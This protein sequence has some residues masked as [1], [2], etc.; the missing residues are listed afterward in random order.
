MYCFK[1]SGENIGVSNFNPG[2]INSYNSFYAYLK[3]NGLASSSTS[4]KV[5]FNAFYS[6]F[7]IKFF[8]SDSFINYLCFKGVSEFVFNSSSD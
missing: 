2:F 4:S 5:F 1:D 3:A 8:N 6:F 7:W